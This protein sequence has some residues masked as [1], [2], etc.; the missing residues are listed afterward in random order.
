MSEPVLVT[1][2][3]G[4]VGRVLLRRLLADGRKVRALA[5]SDASEDAVAAL[6]AEAVRGDVLD[7]VSLT[8]AMRG[9]STVKP[10]V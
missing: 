3:S 7:L 2:G 4:V 9:C 1:G 10:P 5:R 6:G 8:E